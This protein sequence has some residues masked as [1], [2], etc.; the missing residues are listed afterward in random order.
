MTRSHEVAG[1]NCA[2]KAS[3]FG[4]VP[5]AEAAFRIDDG[6]WRPM[7]GGDGGLFGATTPVPDRPFRL[8]VRVTDQNRQQDI[9]TIEVSRSQA[10]NRQPTG[11]D[12]GSI[13]AW[14]ERHLLGTRL[15]PNR[16]G[17]KW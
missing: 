2:I 1:A 9:D 15:G 17:R 11:S 4:A 10:T 16:N 3:A 5:I 14:A 6:E 12:A 13:G 7:H 8:C